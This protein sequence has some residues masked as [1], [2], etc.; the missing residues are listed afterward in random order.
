VY[1]GFDV[2]LIGTGFSSNTKF[3]VK[4]GAKLI[5]KNCEFHSN[6]AVA[7]HVPHLATPV[8][9]QSVLVSASNDG[10]FTFGRGASFAFEVQA[11]AKSSNAERDE[12]T[13][14]L[15]HQLVNLHRTIGELQ[16]GLAH[17][18]HSEALLIS[19]LRSLG[20]ALPDELLAQL[21]QIQL[22]PQL[23]QASSSGDSLRSSAGVLR[24]DARQAPSD[25]A[26]VQAQRISKQEREIVIFI[27]S[28]FRDM[29]KERDLL[30][31]RIF[32]K[33]RKMAN[34][35]DV[36]FSYVDLR[37]GVTGAQQIAALSMCLREISRCNV[38][39][40]LFAER[41]GWSRGSSGDSLIGNVN[42]QDEALTR[43]FE[44]AS[45][46]FPWINEFGDRSIT[47]VESRMVIGNHCEHPPAAFF[48]MRDRYYLEELPPDERVHH[49][50]EGQV[51]CAKLSKLKGDI[52]SSGLPVSEYARPELVAEKIGA[53]L[54]ALVEALFPKG[55]ELSPLQSERFRQAAFAKQLRRIYLA[56]P[57]YSAELDKYV[58]GANSG[59]EK[60]L[61]VVGVAGSGKSAL[62]ANWAA[63]HK[64][65][66]PEDIVITHYIGSTPSSTLYFAIL[67]RILRELA[68]LAHLDSPQLPSE[69]ESIIEQFAPR[70]SE[71]VRKIPERVVIVIDALDSLD[72]RESAKELTW[73]PYTFPARV[74]V[75]LSV[76]AH[77][78]S[79]L[80]VLTN[81]NYAKLQTRPLVQGERRA[82][83]RKHLDAHS[84]KLSEAQEDVLSQAQQCE[85]PRFLR[86]LLDDIIAEGDFDTLDTHI[87]QNLRARGTA[88]LYAQILGRISREI[89]NS[90]GGRGRNS[91]ARNIVK[92]VCSLVWASRHGLQQAELMSILQQ[93]DEISEEL[94]LQVFST[95]EDLFFSSS[96]LLNFANVDIRAAV[97][98]EFLS[99][100]AERKQFHSYIAD[101]FRS[102]VESYPPRK[103]DELPWQLEKA[104][105]WSALREILSDLHVFLKIYTPTNKFDLFRYWRSVERNS[106]AGDC[107]SAYTQSLQYSHQFPA[108]V[109]TGDLFTRVG[110]FLEEMAKFEA[111]EQIYKKAMQHFINSSQPLEAARI[112]YCLAR[113][114]YPLARHEEADANLKHA[115]RVFTEQKG[116]DDLEVANILNRLGVLY[117]EQDKLVE[118][119]SAYARCL[120]IRQEKLGATHSRVGQT[121]KNMMNLY[122]KQGKTAE[123]Y[124]VGLKALDL[125]EKKYGPDNPFTNGIV[126]R[127]GQLCTSLQRFDEAHTWLSRALAIN[128]KI[129]GKQHPNTAEVVYLIGSN[130]FI[131][132]EHE[133][134]EKHFLAA[135]DLVAAV[136]GTEHPD[137]ARVQNR[138]ATLYVEAVRYTEAERCFLAALRVR[139]ARL[140]P[141]HSRVAQTLKHLLTLY[142]LQEKYEEALECGKR[143]LKITE[144]T[145]GSEHQHAAAILLRLGTLL[146]QMQRADQGTAAL[147]RCI[148]I[149]K[150]KFGAD[151]RLSKESTALLDELLNPKAP[152]AVIP[153]PPPLPQSSMFVEKSAPPPADATRNALLDQIR[154]ANKSQVIK[155]KGVQTQQKAA[156]WWGQNYSYAE[157]NKAYA[158]QIAK[159]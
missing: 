9:S 136:Y 32:P 4:F 2:V 26:G 91:A 98:S 101:Y 66:H 124:Q 7:V 45:S 138:L 139:E 3:R 14:M 69:P 13:T 57:E 92:N 113:I 148:E 100:H 125:T 49:E 140:G 46:E 24:V 117:T 152:E 158:R 50:S 83:I 95:L 15:A 126:V 10:G 52:T 47:E 99:N 48:Y 36:N 109:I 43:A 128:E 155:T 88:E 107:A 127:L 30:V 130:D 105:Q 51:E 146:F 120:K 64:Q 60:P 79:T 53:D 103:V 104:E 135:S 21:Q 28:T 37:W 11:I 90:A 81:R 114:Y 58:N 141:N 137:Y 59:D 61:V 39:L 122:E 40:G 31:K 149:Y 147:K 156:N 35:R 159:K 94:W 42:K 89:E 38:F 84:K 144:E 151:H 1:G 145:F 33:I 75:I 108:E 63:D 112:N 55:S 54:A 17:A 22:L 93:H 87:R 41:Y 150:N 12:A 82:L 67:A 71:L 86:V 129:Y 77:S 118:A 73:L 34:E 115:L 25:A 76:S 119:E 116:P 121:L 132:G 16:S 18:L 8:R 85:N 65:R 68:E 110:N 102:S 72:E 142:E 106:S 80:N 143:A 78:A 153:P 5:V 131:R 134:A 62:L 27:S 20:T 154:H 123:G 19:Q 133:Q 56:S 44:M 6:S 70:I 97:E 29:Q 111:S 157:K 74:R 23:Q 96:G